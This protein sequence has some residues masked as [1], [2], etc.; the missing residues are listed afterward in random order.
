MH[1][2]SFR[3]GNHG[4]LSRLRHLPLRPEHLDGLTR[5]YQSMASVGHAL[6]FDDLRQ[7]LTDMGRPPT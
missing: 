2:R 7:F 1:L 3:S 4:S 5:T 6:L